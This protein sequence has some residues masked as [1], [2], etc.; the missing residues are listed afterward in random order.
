MIPSRNLSSCLKVAVSLSF[1]FFLII[2][3][4]PILVH[5]SLSSSNSNNLQQ[6]RKM[7][8]GSR[9]PA[10]IDKCVNCR[11]CL[12]TLVVPSR[13]RKGFTFKASAHGDDG[14][15][16]LLSWKCRCGNKLYQP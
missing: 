13:Q 5:G 9:P 16:Y 7:V 12:A 14:S 6:R 4:A 10:C 15:Y 3:S 2:I 11:P 1:I 8:L